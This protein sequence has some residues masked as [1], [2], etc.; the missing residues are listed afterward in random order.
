MISH[1]WTP[2]RQIIAKLIS[3]RLSRKAMTK[4]EEEVIFVA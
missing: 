2:L 4:E 1:G 3:I